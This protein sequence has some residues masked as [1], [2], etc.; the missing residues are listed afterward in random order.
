MGEENKTTPQVRFCTSCGAKLKE[1]AAFC[2]K[3]GAK[4]G[5]TSVKQETGNARSAKTTEP[6]K[7]VGE[8]N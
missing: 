1:S 7:G 2:A 8:L 4:V 5:G 6:V 3:C